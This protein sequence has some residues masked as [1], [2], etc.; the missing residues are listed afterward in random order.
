MADGGAPDPAI[1]SNTPLPG[2][3]TFYSTVSAENFTQQFRSLM[4]EQQKT[5][6][7]VQEVLINRINDPMIALANRLE[8]LLEVLTPTMPGRSQ[9]SSPEGLRIPPRS[10]P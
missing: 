1:T 9:S 2:T 4:E 8:R 3:R 6:L 10:S 7:E 5:M